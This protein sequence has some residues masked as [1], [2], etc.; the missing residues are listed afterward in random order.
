MPRNARRKSFTGYYHIIVRGVGKQVIF[1]KKMDYLVFL[2]KMRRYI[3]EENIVLIAYCLMENHVHFLLRD[4]E[5]HI[6]SFMHKL[7]GSYAMYFNKKYERCGHLFDERYK[8]E[9]IEDERY[10]L[11]AFRYILQNPEKAGIARTDQYRW[12]SYA[13]HAYENALTDTSLI[14]HLI[15]G[16]DQFESFVK[17][18]VPEIERD[19]CDREALND[20][21]NRII[22][23]VL[24]TTDATIVNRLPIQERDRVIRD[25]RRNNMSIRTIARKTGISKNIV[26]RVCKG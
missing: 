10:L 11:A 4:P 12:N 15:G 17:K 23:T 24:G 3:P 9:C 20:R 22:E 13:E 6:A 26:E 14:D 21:N 5:D 16:K 7:C 2:K 8:S 1:E 19:F 25:L 18:P